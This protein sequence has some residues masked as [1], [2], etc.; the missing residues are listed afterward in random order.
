MTGILNL[1]GLRELDRK[2]LEDEY[3]VKAEPAAISRLCPHC[4]ELR[5]INEISV[6]QKIRAWLE[7]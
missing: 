5:G 2:E 6:Q 1:P 7:D 3:H 4:G